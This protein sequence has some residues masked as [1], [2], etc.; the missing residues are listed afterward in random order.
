MRILLI[1]GLLA[2]VWIGWKYRRLP[3]HLKQQWLKKGLIAL[4]VTILLGLV[5]TGRIHGLFAILA[6][7][8]PFARRLGALLGS[9]QQM[10]Q[11]VDWL[12]RRQQPG[13]S[14]SQSEVTTERLRMILDHTSGT[15]DGTV[16]TGRYAQQLLSKLSIEAI[17]ELYN[18]CPESDK[19]SRQLLETYLRKM[20]HDEWQAYQQQEEQK[21]GF[22][23]EMSIDEAAQIL[24]VSVSASRTEIMNAHRHLMH[25]IHPDRG[26]SSYLAS[27]LNQARDILLKHLSS[28]TA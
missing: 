9:W 8:L 23:S 26:G 17:A 16:L 1:L 12:K 10:K 27:K 2:L 21:Q 24:G 7:L 3:P 19:D 25:N 28:K 6:A 4:A 15:I 18:T 13:V 5:I 20:R 14:S 11:V 22:Q